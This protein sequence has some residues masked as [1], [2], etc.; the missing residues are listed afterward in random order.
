MIEG[1]S[2]GVQALLGTLLTWF[3]TALGAAGVFVLGGVHASNQKKILS[4]SLG[5][6]AGVMLAASYWSLLAPAIELSKASDFW[7]ANEVLTLVPICGGFFLGALF[8]YAADWVIDS[9]GVTNPTISLAVA[10]EKYGTNPFRNEEFGREHNYYNGLESGNSY[11]QKDD[12]HTSSENAQWKRIF[13]LIVAITVHNIPEGLAVGVG[14]GAIGRSHLATFESACTLAWGIGLQNFPEG[15]S[16]SLP[17]YASGFSLRRAFWYGQ[18]SGM[19]E[20]IAGVLGALAV[21]LF[22]PVLPWALAFAAGAMIY[23][24][25]SE[26]V[27]EAHQGGYDKLANW[28]A[29]AGFMVMMSLDVGLG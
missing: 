13:L 1:A 20:P 17:L 10:S 7:N 15:L 26:V 6:A 22:E 9:L 21:S 24:V 19:V 29:M 23:V 4:A 25:L 16:V 14:F 28:S 5:F 11:G 12:K 18:L 3:L 27:P 2:P 8:V